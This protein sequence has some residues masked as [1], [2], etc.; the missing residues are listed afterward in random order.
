MINFS[1]ILEKVAGF[2]IVSS[3][4]AVATVVTFQIPIVKIIVGK[5]S[6]NML[7]QFGNGTDA[8]VLSSMFSPSRGSD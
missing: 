2:K 4:G 7:A 1:A 3:S 5:C 8:A 6:V